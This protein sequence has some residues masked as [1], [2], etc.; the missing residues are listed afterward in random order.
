M[1]TFAGTFGVPGNGGDGGPATSA[2]LNYPVGV[3][4]DAA[5]DVFIS[6]LA[7]YS[8]REVDHSTGMINT[9]AGNGQSVTG[10]FQSLGNG[11]SPTDA[12][13]DQPFG[14]AVDAAGD[15]FVTD[16]GYDDVRE[17]VSGNSVVNFAN[18]NISSP[19][20][21]SGI[22]GSGSLTVTG[23]GT[24][25]IG[26][27][28]AYTGGTTVSGGSTL[29]MATT[30]ALPSSGLITIG[31]GGRLVLGGGSGIGAKLGASS[32]AASSIAA[33]SGV[34]SA[35]NATATTAAPATVVQPTIAVRDAVFSESAATVVA[36]T[37]AARA[38]ALAW[39]VAPTRPD[40]TNGRA[41][42]A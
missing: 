15:L 17:V 33:A 24:L 2:T 29:A 26:G 28:S 10:N 16:S 25:T 31:S 39:V 41:V 34:V 22:A 42:R 6:N 8:V 11:G 20:T 38:V 7:G 1:T 14:V 37:K 23:P 36:P 13:F 21:L 27:T 32:P 9:V 30:A 18:T 40:K 12:Q 4:V 5:G 3:A 35:A 19:Q